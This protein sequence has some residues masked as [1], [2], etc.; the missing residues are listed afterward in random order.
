M[1][2]CW[3]FPRV[4]VLGMVRVSSDE[5]SR[6][7]PQGGMGRPRTTGSSDWSAGNWWYQ[8]WSA[9]PVVMGPCCASPV[10]A[11]GG[12]VWCD[13]ISSQHTECLSVCVC[14]CMC[15]RASVCRFCMSSVCLCV[16]MCGFVCVCVWICADMWV[17]VCVCVCVCLSVYV[18]VCVCVCVFV[19]VCMRLSMCVYADVVQCSLEIRQKVM[20]SD[21]I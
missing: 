15:S 10:V 18:C 3:A 6:Q 1:L 4:G 5:A 2:G 16:S 19:F 12:L 13:S 14:V 11:S 9:N 20:I 17:F 21:Q 7:P 8:L